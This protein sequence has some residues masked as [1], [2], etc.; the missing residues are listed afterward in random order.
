MAQTSSEQPIDEEFAQLAMAAI[1]Q[2]K[3]A[4]TTAQ[5][6]A[7]MLQTTA[8]VEQYQPLLMRSLRRAQHLLYSLESYRTYIYRPTNSGQIDIHYAI[9]QQLAE[10]AAELNN[11]SIEVEV[12]RAYQM[13][14]V[15]GD[16]ETIAEV[17]RLILLYLLQSQDEHELRITVEAEKSTV[18][19]RFR[20]STVLATTIHAAQQSKNARTLNNGIGNEI[21]LFFAKLLAERSQGKL[22]LHKNTIGLRLARSSQLSLIEEKGQ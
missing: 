10:L 8:E 21:I 18:V 3:N 12:H 6:Y 4:L 14:S 7:S 16:S 13:P 15:A 22:W 1:Y 19:L 20:S 2:L 5:G 11:R 9:N 17:I